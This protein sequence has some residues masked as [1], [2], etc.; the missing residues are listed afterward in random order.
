MSKAITAKFGLR[1]A[2]HALLAS[3][4]VI[5]AEAAM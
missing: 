5:N 3:L 4:L 2:G 1:R